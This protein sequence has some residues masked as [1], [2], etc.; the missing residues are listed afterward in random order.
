MWFFVIN[1]V[2]YLLI[3]RYK[4]MLHL[5]WV[6]WDFNHTLILFEV[7]SHFWFDP[8]GCISRKRSSTCSIKFFNSPKQTQIASLY[9]VIDLKRWRTYWILL[10]LIIIHLVRNVMYEPLIVCHQ[11]RLINSKLYKVESMIDFPNIKL[12]EDAIVVERLQLNNSS[13]VWPLLSA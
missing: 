9:Q 6:G 5:S 2:N 3:I 12:I 7:P 13:R 1:C 11:I 4:V 8:V 10:P